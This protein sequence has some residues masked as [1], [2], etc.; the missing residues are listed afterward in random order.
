VSALNYF[1]FRV[2]LLAPNPAGDATQR[3]FV[4]MQCGLCG[5]DF[6]VI[7][8]TANSGFDQDERKESVHRP[9]TTATTTVRGFAG[10]N[11]MV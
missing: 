6:S 10:T 4:A 9:Q 3:H 1:L 5:R 2:S 11:N 7:I 8:P